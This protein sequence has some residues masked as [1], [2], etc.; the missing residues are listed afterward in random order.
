LSIPDFPAAYGRVW[1][2]LDA[3]SIARYNQNRVEVMAA[4]PITAP[5]IV[6][7][8]AHRIVAMALLLLVARCAWL[9]HRRLGRL[10][11]LAKGSRAW[12]GLVAVQIFLGAATIWTGKSADIATAHVAFGAL[13]LMAGAMVTIIA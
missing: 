6:L 2:A 10:H 7:Q 8:M 3:E 9:A 4:N 5:Q 12:L 13:S 11:P 1:P